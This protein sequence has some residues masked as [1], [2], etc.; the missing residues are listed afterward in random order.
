MDKIVKVNLG[1]ALKFIDTDTRNVCRMKSREAFD[2]LVNRRGVG[3]D[4]LGWLDLPS[5]TKE[6]ELQAYRELAQ[7]WKSDG[8]EIVVI[9]GIGGSYLGAR[10]VLD[11]LSQSFELYKEE[12]SWPKVI[13]AGQNFSSDYLAELGE[14]LQERKFA[15]IVVSKSGTT[16]ETLVAFRLVKKLAEQY[17][18][19][20]KAANKIV[21]VTDKSRGVLKALSE[22][23]GYRAFVIPDDVGGRFSVLTSVGLLPVMLAGYDASK[24]ISGAVAMEEICKS[25]HE[26]SPAIQYAAMRNM[27]Y[28]KGYLIEILVNYNPKLKHL[29]EWCKQL[30]SESEGKDGKGIFPASVDYTADLHSMGQYIEQGERILFETVISVDKPCREI[31]VIDDSDNL[32]ELNFLVG[33]SIDECNKMAEAGTRIAHVDG[34][35]PNIT[36]QIPCLDEY[37]IGALLYFF[38]FSCGLSA[39][40]LGV[41]PF[42]QLG[43]E[44]YKRNMFALLGKSGYEKLAAELNRRI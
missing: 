10:A 8:V 40:M 11:S 35:V 19:K 2:T 33:R 27:L 17:Y 21:V 36:I 24:L 31:V 41:N 34:G 4:F 25:G 1:E 38:E 20:S 15:T 37:N 28:E 18:G 12:R 7:E 5:G 6:E 30:F 9:L 44:G 42:N 3:S 43:V 29:S 16:T 23:E 13:F 14:L 26:M 22:K 39:Y 32:D